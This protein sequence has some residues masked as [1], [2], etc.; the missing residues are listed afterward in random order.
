VRDDEPAVLYPADR[1]RPFVVTRFPPRAA[2][3]FEL[4]F[5]DQPHLT[6]AFRELVGVS[7]AAYE[8][9]LCQLRA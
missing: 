8:R 4:G 5:S 1:A 9:R 3:A 7:P 6:R 2:L